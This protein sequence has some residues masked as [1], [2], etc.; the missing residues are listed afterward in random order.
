M[1]FLLLLLLLAFN[2]YG[3]DLTAKSWLIS[4]EKGNIIQSEN[5]N[6]V[7]PIASITKLL[8]AI[9]VLESGVDM[10]ED[11]KTEEFGLISRHE[12][13]NMALVRSNNQAAMLLCNTYPGG[14][15]MCIKDMNDKLQSLGMVK[16]KVYEPTGLDPRNKSTAEELIK[17]VKE[18]VKYPEI[19]AASSKSGVEIK[20]RKKWV[21][22][23]NTNPLIGT[24]HNILVS[25]TG[26]TK[27]AGGCI[28]MYLSTEKGP[29]VI[30]VLGSLNTHTRVP[31]AEFI[32]NNSS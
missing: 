14:Y 4:D 28:V 24:K 12:L 22:F 32:A 6:Q 5:T 19:I 10:Q 17:L 1:K 25:K 16:S 30:I 2:S 18:S 9:I 23:K 26:W 20:I 7:R 13:L 3:D 15:K 31:E 11:I 29:R 8:T 21:F 27:K